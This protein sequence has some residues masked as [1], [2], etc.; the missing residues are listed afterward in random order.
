[1]KVR[2]L[3]VNRQPMYADEKL[4]FVA[5]SRKELRA[6]FAK[7]AAAYYKGRK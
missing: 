7:M 3:W 1:M 4:H 5:H 6:K 2:V